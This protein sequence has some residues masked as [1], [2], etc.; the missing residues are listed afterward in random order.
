M[1]PKI[2]LLIKFSEFVF[3]VGELRKWKIY[4]YKG[5][6]RWKTAATVPNKGLHNVLQLLIGHKVPGADR[7]LQIRIIVLHLPSE[8]VWILE[9]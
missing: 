2:Q 8:A 3:E 9:T 4:F 7:R 1:Y 5:A 6:E